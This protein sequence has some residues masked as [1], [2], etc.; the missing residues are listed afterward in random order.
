MCIRDSWNAQHLVNEL[1]AEGLPMV[2]IPQNTGGMGPGSKELEKLVYGG[3]LAHGGN[4]VLRYCAG[5]VSLL[6]DSNG[7]YRPNKKTS[8]ENGRIDGI[9]ATVMALG[10]YA[11]PDETGD[12]DGFFASPA[13]AG[14]SS[15]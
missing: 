14:T 8:K 9:V 1:I 5:N 3:M 4:P 15:R 11:R 7:N 6:F 10:R 2:N 12:E 13:T